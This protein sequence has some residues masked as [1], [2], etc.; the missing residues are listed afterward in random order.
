M[1]VELRPWSLADGPSLQSAV[2]ASPDLVTQLGG[3]D[4]RDLEDCTRFIEAHLQA[5]GPVRYDVAI[6]VDGSAVGN[7]GLSSID[8]AHQT[9]WTYYWVAATHRAQGLG[10]HALATVS[11]WALEELGVFRLE[12]GHRVNNP[13]SCRVAT[14][15][16][17]IA[18]GLE[19]SK[20][21]YGDERFDVE[22]HARLATD[23]VPPLALLPM[24]GLPSVELRET[25]P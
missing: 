19:R 5:L 6:T 25:T 4:L 22:T 12:L 21:R 8:R 16:G 9:A 13:A 14:R 2:A 1:R 23:P 15:A 24:R 7:V 20:L 10:S 18:E 11:R 3:A 17:F